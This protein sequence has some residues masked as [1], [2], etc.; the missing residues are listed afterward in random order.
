MHY[1]FYKEGQKIQ[2]QCPK[3]C[4]CKQNLS[5]PL[6]ISLNQSSLLYIIS[7]IFKRINNKHIYLLKK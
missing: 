3:I 7:E 6:F 1:A 5:N 2:W 4:K